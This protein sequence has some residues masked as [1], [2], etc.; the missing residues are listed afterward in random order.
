M[1]FEDGQY[2]CFSNNLIEGEGLEFKNVRDALL[3]S[4]IVQHQGDPITAY[5]TKRV[6][7]RGLDHSSPTVPNP[8]SDVWWGLVHPRGMKYPHWP[9]TF[10]PSRITLS[11]GMQFTLRGGE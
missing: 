1:L 6:T 4:N 9:P 7:V 11:D 10:L 8:A 5:G 2:L 3:S